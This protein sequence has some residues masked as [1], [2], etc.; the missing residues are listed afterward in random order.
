MGR[1][2]R[3]RVRGEE[4]ESRGEG[5]ERG[6]RGTQHRERRGQ[7]RAAAAAEARAPRGH[8]PVSTRDCQHEFASGKA[9]PWSWTLAA[10][11]QQPPNTTLL[12]VKIL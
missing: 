10:N 6:E 3:G 1:G 2:E 11:T 7:E 8:E 5:V 4:E 12:L 9:G